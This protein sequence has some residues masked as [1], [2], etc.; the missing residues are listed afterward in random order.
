M[1]ILV[2]YP[3][4]QSLYD[5]P[6][7]EENCFLADCDAFGPCAYFVDEDWYNEWVK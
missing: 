3:E 7:F 1:F 5:L 6:D 2:T 4:S